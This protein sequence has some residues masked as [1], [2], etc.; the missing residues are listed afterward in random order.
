MT[1]PPP[2]QPQPD[3]FQQY[4]PAPQPMQAPPKKGKK[5][6]WILGAI[7]VIIALVAIF[8]GGDDTKKADNTASSA[9]KGGSDNSS[10]GINTPVRDGKFEFTVTGVEKNLSSVGDNPYLTQQAQGQFV[11]VSVKVENIGD[12]P[13]SFSPTSQKVVD[14]QGRSFEPDTTAQ[15]ALGGSD[16]PI[17]DNIN[18]GNS[19]DVKLVYDMPKNAAPA[20]IELHDSMFSGGASVNLK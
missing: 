16:I 11:I 12:K 9:A 10:A 2:N 7:V 19:V 6:P 13:Q 8:G 18:P 17:W 20:S 14:S 5:W 3:A 1:Q 4:P 15:V